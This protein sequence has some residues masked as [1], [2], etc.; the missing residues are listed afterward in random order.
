MIYGSTGHLGDAIARRA[1]QLGLRPILA[2]RNANGVGAQAEELG[3]E[4]KVF[5]LGDSSSIDAA[6]ELSHTVLNCAGPFIHTF[7]PMISACLRTR[8]HYLDLTGEIAVYESLASKNS[9]A[10]ERGIMILPG[11]GFDVVATDCLSLHL[12]NRLPLASNLTLAFHSEGPAGL[13]P[14]T[15]KTAVELIPFGT[16]IR[17]G[18]MIVPAPVMAQSMIDFGQGRINATRLT[19][20]D[21]F[22]AHRSTGIPNIEDYA[23][24]PEEIVRLLRVLNRFRALFRIGIVREVV[25][26]LV[27][28]GSTAEERA[29]TRMHV[30][31]KVEDEEGRKAVSRLH[32]PEGGVNWTTLAALAVVT[33]VLEGRSPTGFQTP[34]SAYGA[35]LVLETEGVTREDIA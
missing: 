13:P 28:A 10:R 12:K 7:E 8:T 19:W 22:M 14:G 21:I 25:K 5:R 4:H 30:W 20:G 29:K 11:A 35:D 6:L 2:G 31:G 15:A 24:L 26:R 3:L 18:G 32:G 17:R 23:V 16:L 1:V 34:A 27:P 33:K 9:E